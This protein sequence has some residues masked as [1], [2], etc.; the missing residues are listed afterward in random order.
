MAGNWNRVLPPSRRPYAVDN[1]F[2]L[3]IVQKSQGRLFG[4]ASVDPIADPWGAANEV[5]KMVKEHGFRAVKLYPTYQHYDPRDPAC[6]PL[7]E[8]ATSLGIPVHFHMGWTPVRSAKIEYQQPW[9]LDEIGNRFPE[10][11]VVICHLATPWT[12]EAAGIIARHDNFY[13]D[14]S[15]LGIWH[16]RKI[17]Q[18][19]HDFGCMNPYEK[20]LYGSENPFTGGYLET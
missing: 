13:G 6:D 5:E 17:Y 2:V 3:D 18:I 7:Y 20:L 14:V 4:I 16:P 12:D 9:R 11:K 1:E 19:I 15:A 10:L 8:T